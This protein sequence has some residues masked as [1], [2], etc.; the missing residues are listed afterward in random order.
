MTRQP[1]TISFWR[2]VLPHWEVVNGRYF[3]TIRLAN[4]LPRRVVEELGAVLADA[5][6]KDYLKKSRAYFKQM[7]QWLDKNTG[8]TWL[9]RADVATVVQ[10]TIEKYVQIG[11]WYVIAAVTMPNHAHIFFRCGDRSLSRVMRSFKRYTGRACN[12]L[13]GRE[14]KRFWQREW[15]DHWSRGADEDDKIVSY[16]RNNPVRAGLVQDGEEWPW[17]M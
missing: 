15:F 4:S 7:E 14:G 8:E 5:K 1:D 17:M 11:H 10:S 9:R 16:I 13:L 12:E 3:V 2:G 6:E